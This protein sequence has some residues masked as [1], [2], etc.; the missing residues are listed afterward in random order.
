MSRILS[1]VERSPLR[2]QYRRR[3]LQS[4]ARFVRIDQ[5]SWRH[6]RRGRRIEQPRSICRPHR[7]GLIRSVTPPLSR[8]CSALRAEL[9]TPTAAAAADSPSATGQTYA[10]PWSLGSDAPS[11]LKHRK[12]RERAQRPLVLAPRMESISHGGPGLPSRH[13]GQDQPWPAPS[14]SPRLM[15]QIPYQFVA[16]FRPGLQIQ[17]RLRSNHARPIASM[18]S[19]ACAERSLSRSSALRRLER[20]QAHASSLCPSTTQ[21]RRSG[22]AAAVKADLLQDAQRAHDRPSTS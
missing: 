19:P 3:S 16:S 4:G 21:T 7:A 1:N 6:H 9:P 2:G 18:A 10:S 12:A 13:R 8:N 17:K 11:F 14:T 15:R 22:P 20:A 5:K